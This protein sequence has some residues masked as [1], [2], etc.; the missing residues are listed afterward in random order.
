[1]RAR[2]T[3]LLLLL[4]SCHPALSD[5][6]LTYDRIHLSVSSGEEVENDTLIAILYAQ[7]EGSNPSSLSRNVNL[8]ISKAVERAKQHPTIAVQTLEYHT[9][10][11][12]N[13]Q[14]LSGWR[15]RQS[16][17]LK[18]LDAP[19]LS[20]LIGELQGWLMLSAISYEVSPKLRND[21]EQRLT[22]DAVSAF[23]ER[24]TLLAKEWGRKDYRLVELHVTSSGASPHLY[25][26]KG[27]AMSMQAEAV[28]PTLEA[29]KQRIEVGINGTVELKP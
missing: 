18:S 4:L 3:V 8:A 19:L 23:R 13:K 9:S 28:P 17:Q 25:R 5:Q 21:T 22:A 26:S 10:P 15:V 2:F 6:P 14:H 29:G 24:A 20:E 11:V 12:Y 1:M 16:I 27:V 7:E